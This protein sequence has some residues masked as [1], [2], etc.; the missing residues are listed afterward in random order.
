MLPS[1]EVIT[2]G[3]LAIKEFYKKQSEIYGYEIKPSYGSVNRVA[4]NALKEKDFTT[5]IAIF[6]E[7]AKNH[8]YKADAYD[9][10]ADGYE[11]NGELDKALEMRNLVLRKSVIEN[12]ENNAYKTRQL[13][14][15][16]LV[17]ANKNQK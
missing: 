11:A 9:S 14:L 3:I 13:N 4:Y 17:E 16:K 6:K 7:N 10:L 2:K 8:P 5:A 1:H 12:V 15:L